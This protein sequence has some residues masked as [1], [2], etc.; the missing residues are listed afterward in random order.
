MKLIKKHESAS[1]KVDFKL[2]DVVMKLKEVRV[3]YAG[4][5]KSQDEWMNVKED[6]RERSIPLVPTECGKVK[7]G[8]LILCFQV[9]FPTAMV[10]I[11]SLI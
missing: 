6:V 1:G 10:T 9:I 2:L 4:F 8:D 3:R 11:P 7:E 5:S